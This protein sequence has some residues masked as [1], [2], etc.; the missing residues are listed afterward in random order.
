MRCLCKND[1][2]FLGS[3]KGKGTFQGIPL[4]EPNVPLLFS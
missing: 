2:E 1:D 3:I 4:L